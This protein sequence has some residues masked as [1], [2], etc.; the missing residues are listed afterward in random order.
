MALS[1][2]L[3]LVGVDLSIDLQRLPRVVSMGIAKLAT[4]KNI[5]RSTQRRLQVGK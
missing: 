3:Q 1:L 2:L 5:Q 4:E